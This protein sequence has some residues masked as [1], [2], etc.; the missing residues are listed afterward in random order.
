MEL[1]K[2]IR[3]RVLEMRSQMTVEEWD[4]K[5]H[6]IFQK[7]VTHPFFLHANTI[8]CYVNYRN[9]VETRSIIEW[10]WKQQKAVAVPRIEGTEMNFYYIQQFSDL[11][12]GYFGIPEPEAIRPAKAKNPLVIM[13]GTVY[14]KNRNRI[15]YGKGFYD[16][17]LTEHSGCS[18][19]ALGFEIQIMDEIPTDGHD[20]RPA[21]LIT[22]EHI[23]DK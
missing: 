6:A 19:I 14:D 8:Y 17:F 5:S 12:E 21:V 7:V 20:I 2:D 9:E 1:K 22:E 18:T 10:A 23:Y 13:P 11:Q 15:G 4:E 3:K 16:K